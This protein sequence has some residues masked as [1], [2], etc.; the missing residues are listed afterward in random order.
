VDDALGARLVETLLRDAHE[1]VRILLAG[2]HCFAGVLHAGLELGA[3]ALVAE[4]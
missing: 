3:H 1:L 2:G 4:A